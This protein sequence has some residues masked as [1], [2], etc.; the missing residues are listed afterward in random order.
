MG[1]HIRCL[2]HIV[3]KEPEK[4]TLII[5]NAANEVGGI[6]GYEALVWFTFNL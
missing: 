1:F 2:N 5:E 4:E 3:G 6:Y